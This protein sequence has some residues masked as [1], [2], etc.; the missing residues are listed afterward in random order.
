[1]KVPSSDAHWS[2]WRRYCDVLGLT[3][4]Q[5]VACLISHELATVVDEAPNSAFEVQRASQERVNRLDAHVS[6]T[7]EPRS[8]KES[9]ACCVTVRRG[10]SGR[11]RRHAVRV[12]L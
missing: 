8:C 11:R 9:R 12:Q 7:T 5:G 6:W 4:G 1:M 10:S 2:T 3:M